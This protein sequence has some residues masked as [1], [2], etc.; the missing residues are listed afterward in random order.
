MLIRTQL[1]VN[2]NDELL[3]YSLNVKAKIFPNCAYAYVI[4]T[5]NGLARLEQTA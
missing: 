5:E 1:G 2:I 3:P 4:L